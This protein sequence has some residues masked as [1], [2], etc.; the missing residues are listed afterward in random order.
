MFPV[1]S[2]PGTPFR[3]PCC[4]PLTSPL[5]PLDCDGVSDA[6]FLVA[7]TVCRRLLRCP[8]RCLVWDLPGVCTAGYTEVVRFGNKHPKE[9]PP[10]RHILW[11]LLS[12][13]DVAGRGPGPPGSGGVAGASS[14]QPLLACL[15]YLLGQ[16]VT[17]AAPW[18][19]LSYGSS[20]TGCPSPHGDSSVTAMSVW[21]WV[22]VGASGQDPAPRHLAPAL[23][24]RSPALGC[25][26]LVMSPPPPLFA[27]LQAF[28]VS[29]P[30]LPGAWFLLLENGT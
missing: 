11:G 1:L 5:F 7:L 17:E 6:L 30:F 14:I 22:P 3:D 20:V 29:L 23:T 24:I 25:C 19:P 12:P 10:S 16:P 27:E 15:S 4:D 8:V 28:L 2:C 18:D 9:R 26:V 13:L 21:T